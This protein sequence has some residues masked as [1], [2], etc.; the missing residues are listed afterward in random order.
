V[1]TAI[2]TYT[3]QDVLKR[4]SIAYDEAA[5]ERA[6]QRL[7]AGAEDV[8]P[9][10]YDLDHFLWRVAADPADYIEPEDLQ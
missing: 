10:V 8:A 7:F 5:V 9:G 3:W 6:A 2:P 1:E 4:N